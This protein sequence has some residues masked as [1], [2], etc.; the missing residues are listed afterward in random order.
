MSKRPLAAEVQAAIDTGE[1]C[2]CGDMANQHRGATRVRPC[3][4]TGCECM[5]L[6]MRTAAERSTVPVAPGYQHSM[7]SIWKRLDDLRRDDT[8]DPLFNVRLEGYLDEARGCERSYRIRV[9][10]VRGI[11]GVSTEQWELVLSLA[12][13]YGRRVELD[14]S[15]MVLE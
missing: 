13:Q 9:T 6:D 12:G 5:D 10:P 4:V 8:A 1:R 2:Q 3:L 7:V 11:G 14:N 15:A